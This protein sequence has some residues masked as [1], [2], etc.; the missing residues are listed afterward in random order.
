LKRPRRPAGH[1]LL[2]NGRIVWDSPVRLA[3][4]LLLL[5]PSLALAQSE[6][7]VYDRP[8]VDM[9]GST[10][11]PMMLIDENTLA[12]G[13]F[14]TTPFPVKPWEEAKACVEALSK[15]VALAP[16]GEPPPILVV[17]VA[18]TIRVRDMTLDSL[19]YASDSTFGGTHFSAP[20]VA[21][22]LV[23]SNALLV[24]ERYRENVPVL[25]HEALHFILWRSLRLYGHPE[26]FFMPC[27]KAYSE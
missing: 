15:R 24:V 10:T 9:L 23:R 12:G 1:F 21:Y 5:L 27:D 25:R 22:S 26:K 18:R 14:V 2:S 17:P 11:L 16:I 7:L 20:T 4:I 19:D 6:A 8:M 13:L 3:G